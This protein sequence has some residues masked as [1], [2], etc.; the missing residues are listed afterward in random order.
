MHIPTL[1]HF[2]FNE[3]EIDSLQRYFVYVYVLLFFLVP[4][5]IVTFYLMSLFERRRKKFI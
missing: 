5:F 2:N 4:L 1:G 3:M